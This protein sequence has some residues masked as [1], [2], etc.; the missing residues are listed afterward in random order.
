MPADSAIAPPASS[1]AA[2]VYR[3]R[4]AGIEVS[5]GERDF[6]AGAMQSLERRWQPQDAVEHVLVQTMALIDL[7]LVRLDTRSGPR[8]QDQGLDWKLAGSVVLD[9]ASYGQAETED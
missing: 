5:A 4:G 8:F 2:V 9:G 6:L 7:K 1:R 3:L